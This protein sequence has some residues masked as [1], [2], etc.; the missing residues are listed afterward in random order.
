MRYGAQDKTAET[1]LKYLD[2]HQQQVRADFTG[3]ELFVYKSDVVTEVFSNGHGYA[4][5]VD[6]IST[7]LDQH[8][9]IR[10]IPYP[11]YSNAC[12]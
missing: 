7:Y 12:P 10:L 4:Y 5:Y 11:P 8:P 2:E 6:A 3:L 1:F 9:G